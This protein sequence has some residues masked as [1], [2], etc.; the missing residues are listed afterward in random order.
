MKS[1]NRILFALLL[2]G[3]TA[4]AEAGNL[5][6]NAD[7]QDDWATQIPQ[8]KTLHWTYAS[9]YQNRRDYNPDGWI[10]KGSWEWQD[11]D[12][13]PGERRLVLRAPKAEIR[14]RVNWIAVNDDRELTGFP[15][16]GKFPKLVPVRSRSPLR[17]V[18]DLKLRVRV[19]GEDVLGDGAKIELG[20]AP[21]GEVSS[22]DPLGTEPSPT[23]SMAAALPSGSFDWRWIEVVLP[24]SE[25][26]KAATDPAAKDAAET[27]KAGPALPAAIT[28]ALHFAGT[29]GRIEVARAELTEPGPQSPSWLPNGGF[30]DTREGGMP[31]AWGDPARYTYFPPGHYY[32]FTTWHND[33][34]PNRG[35][36]A[37]DELVVRGGRRSLRMP[38]PAGDEVAVASAPIRIAQR[39][40]R[41]IEVTAWVKT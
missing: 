32:I 22:A 8:N 10:L 36:P 26:L 31:A 40:Q 39:E 34:F 38:V 2:A 20:L 24:A 5:L 25:W 17:M 27:A 23:V 15:D 33:G 18:R 7:F 9:E 35:V 28:V 37:L 12:R 6:R 29:N 21:P 19:R 1:R 41:L 13:P 4:A 11:A 16:A 14:Q 3:S 30:E